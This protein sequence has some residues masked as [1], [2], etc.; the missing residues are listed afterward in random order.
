M[1]KKVGRERVKPHS[2]WEMEKLK[3]NDSFSHV[4]VY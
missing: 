3:E 2:T 4:Q 1:Q